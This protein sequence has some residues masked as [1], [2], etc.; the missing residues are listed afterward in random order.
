MR[1][2]EIF[3]VDGTLCDVSGVRHHVRGE[4]R[5]FEAFHEAALGCP[6]HAWVVDGARAAAREGRAVVV[7]T[8]RREH[9]R[10]GTSFWLALHDVPSDHLYL[11]G[12]HD[13]RADVEVKRDVLA[14]VRQRYRV[15]RA[16]DD[17]P[18][19]IALWESEGIDVVVVPGWDD[20]PSRG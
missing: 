4:R 2:A 11:R 9:W 15:V 8:A 16:W 14:Q 5:N 20:E 18:N 13:G 10:A 7:V 1:E 6:P 19:V 3:D 17:N 12:E